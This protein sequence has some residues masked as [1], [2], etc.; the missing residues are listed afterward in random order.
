MSLAENTPA[1]DG[2]LAEI[3][4][5]LKAEDSDD[6]RWVMY[7][8]EELDPKITLPY[9]IEGILDE[10]RAVR[11][12]ASEVLENVPAEV[13]ARELVPLLGSERIEVRNIVAAIF[14]KYGEA[15]IDPLLEALFNGNEDVRKFSADILGLTRKETA[16]E[17][18]C[19]VVLEDEVENVAISAVEALGKIGSSMALPTLFKVLNGDRGMQAEA[20]EAIGLIADPGAV[21]EL[22]KHLTV[23][24]PI[25]Q[26][27][28]IE[29]LGTLGQES[30]LDKLQPLIDTAPDILKEQITRTILTIGHK[31][32]CC[33]L[34]RFSG[35]LLNYLPNL[36]QDHQQEM[37]NLLS[38]QL[39]LSPSK[40]ILERLF[41]IS[42]KLPSS[43]LVALINTVKDKPDMLQHICHL[44]DV[45]DDWV[46]YTA[47]EAL[48]EH[49]QQM[50]VETI[51]KVLHEG[52]GLPVL[53]A[54]KTVGRLNLTAA[55]HDIL[56][57]TQHI[58]EDIR[59]AAE[60][61]LAELKD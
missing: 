6:R 57:L 55:R 4:A 36:M 15:V 18:L 7:D 37:V 50:A 26:Y 52:D 32:D 33:V 56:R 14:V 43:L 48:G 25:I 9:L 24:N 27:A 39:T 23:S 8:L 21:G 35:D 20:A 29:A 61:A 47:L 19:Q 40:E 54:L 59:G 17:S 11:E 41:Q 10:H 38:H 16:V 42:E 44:V 53:A 22:E 13:G 1:P 28:V 51:Q 45:E 12:A 31:R 3:V 5:N 2:R 30:S 60:R 34:G 46:A 58:D 49:D